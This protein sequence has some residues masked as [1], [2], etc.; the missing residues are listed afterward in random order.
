M[1]FI[2][3]QNNPELFGHLGL[4]QQNRLNK[5]AGILADLISDRKTIAA[6]ESEAKEGLKGLAKLAYFQNN[7]DNAVP[8]VHTFD[9][10][11][12]QVNFINNYV[13]R[14]EDHYDDIV[15]TLGP[16]HPLTEELVVKNCV[17][18]DGTALPPDQVTTYLEELAEL[19][20]RYGATAKV[21]NRFSATPEFHNRRH[22][23]LSLGDNLILEQVLPIQVQFSTIENR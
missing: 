14:D 4:S 17:V 16:E 13:I 11:G 3:E 6:D 19:N 12:L 15:E 18:I 2:T 23:L 1:A 22:E 8:P 9:F 20:E 10:N 5:R 21:E 7:E